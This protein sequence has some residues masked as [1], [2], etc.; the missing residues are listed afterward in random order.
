MQRK[1]S[2]LIATLVPA[3]AT[4]TTAGAQQNQPE[5]QPM[6]GHDMS[7]MQ[8]KDMK[9][10]SAGSMELHRIMMSGAKMPM[11]MTDDVDHDFAHMMIMHHQQ[12]I[13]MSDVLLKHGD[14]AEL[15]ALATKMKAEQ[16]KEM[17][18]LAPFKK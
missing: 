15:K 16:Q 2:L 6:Q 14:N 11:P 3:L 13:E 5:P 12:A 8:G 10:H 17:E 7:K 4:A 9:G 1:H 18:E